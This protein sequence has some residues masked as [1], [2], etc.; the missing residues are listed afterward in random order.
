MNNSP[1]ALSG[2]FPR[3]KEEAALVTLATVETTD[4]LSSDMQ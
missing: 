1:N 3:K 4:L 2:G